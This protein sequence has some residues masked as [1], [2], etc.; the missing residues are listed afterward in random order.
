MSPHGKFEPETMSDVQKAFM[1]GMTDQRAANLWDAADFIADLSPEAK[2]WLRNADKKKIEQLNANL[3]F[4]V[5]SKAIW[6]FLW[7]GGSMLGGVLTL[8]KTVGD[9]ITV[10]IK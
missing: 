1:V 8:W 9:Y 2:E 3:E 7:I 4:Y 10:K 6:R 5:T